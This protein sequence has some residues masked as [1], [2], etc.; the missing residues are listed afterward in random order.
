MSMII[1]KISHVVAGFS[2]YII[3]LLDICAQCWY[4]Y[5]L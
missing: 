4:R 5:S 2:Y 1:Y 3:D